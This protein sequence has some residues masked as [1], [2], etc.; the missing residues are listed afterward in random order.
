VLSDL[1]DLRGAAAYAAL[2]DLERLAALSPESPS[3]SDR[4]ALAAAAQVRFRRYHAALG[5]LGPSSDPAEAMAPAV[6]LV[7]EARRRLDTGDWWEGLLTACLSAPLTDDL[8]GALLGDAPA[9]GVATVSD[10]IDE[11]S[12]QAETWA[13][14]RVRA[15]AG[16]D[17][18]LAARLA[19]WGRRLVGEL[20]VLANRLDEERYPELAERLVGRHNRRLADL[21]L[22]T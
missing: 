4:A 11:G 13:A 6:P 15:A 18:A 16:S 1:T 8:F 22:G 7:D 19:L 9:D 12:E 2:T 14:E 5:R 20:I 17:P 21:G 10:Q 3:L